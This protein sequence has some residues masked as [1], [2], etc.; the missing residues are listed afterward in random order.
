MAQLASAPPERGSFPRRL[1]WAA[2]ASLCGLLAAGLWIVRYEIRLTTVARPQTLASI[3]DSSLTPGATVLLSRQAVCSQQ[4]IK[5]KAVPVALQRR[6]F[7]E[8]GMVKV[9]PRAYEVDYLVTPALGGAEDIHN[10]WPQSY[11]AVWNAQVKDALEDRLREL[12][13]RGSLDLSQAQR[14]IANNWIGA[15]RSI[16]RLTCRCRS[17]GS[18]RVRR[19]DGRGMNDAGCSRTR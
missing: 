12:V 4:N 17:T 14:E 2:T 16:F 6:V 11:S 15:Y 18:S 1:L 5:N 19:R 8:Y 7:E 3:P 9:E 13:C 10:L